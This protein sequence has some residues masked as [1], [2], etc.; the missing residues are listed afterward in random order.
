MKAELL[1]QRLEKDFITPQM[2]D[3]W[4]EYMGSI[5]DFLCE[6]FK[7]RSIFYASKTL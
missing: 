6:N 4:A 2:S 1:Y 7:Q 5:T 3:K